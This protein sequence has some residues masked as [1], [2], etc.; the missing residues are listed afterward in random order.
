V[1]YYCDIKFKLLKSK[2]LTLMTDYL[3]LNKKKTNIKVQDIYDIFS[4]EV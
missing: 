4:S 2:I 3:Y 1:N